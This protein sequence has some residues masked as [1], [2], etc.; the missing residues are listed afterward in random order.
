MTI[1]YQENDLKK[2]LAWFEFL[3]RFLQDNWIAA[4]EL[5]AV[6]SHLKL[7]CRSGDFCVFKFY[8][9]FRIREFSFFISGAIIIIIFA[10]FFNARICP[11]CELRENLNLANITS[12][13]A[14]LDSQQRSDKG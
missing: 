13:Y 6:F 7:Y 5:F 14:D 1:G 8:T 11:P 9:K 12:S 3:L 4:A 10:I 2:K